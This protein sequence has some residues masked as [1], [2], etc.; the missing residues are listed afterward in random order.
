MLNLR[1]LFK[2]YK[3]T[4][5]FN[6]QISPQIFIDELLFLTKI[7][8]LGAVLEVRGVDFECLD[9]ASVDGLTK[10][11]ESALKLFNERFRVYQY[12]FRVNNQTIPHKL[13]G[14][15]VVG[16]PITHPLPNFSYT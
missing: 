1:R 2:N 3:E 9:G 13:Y 16:Q 6:E 11:L 10:R 15:P 5:S 14:N 8:D 4:G 7:G 12:I